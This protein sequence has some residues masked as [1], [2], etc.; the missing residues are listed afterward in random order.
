MLLQYTLVGHAQ[1]SIMHLLTNTRQ[2]VTFSSSKPAA[3]RS[4][5]KPPIFR[6]CRPWCWWRLFPWLSPSAAS[7]RAFSGSRGGRGSLSRRVTRLLCSWGLTRQPAPLQTHRSASVH[8]KRK[9][10]TRGQGQCITC[11]GG[12]HPAATQYSL[13]NC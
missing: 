6:R 12:R 11:Q 7:V 13:A 8:V 1:K 10:G 4:L 9:K 2:K 5:V 3:T